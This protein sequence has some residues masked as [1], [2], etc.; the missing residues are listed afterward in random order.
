VNILSLSEIKD[1]TINY[2]LNQ[3]NLIKY[4]KIQILIPKFPRVSLKRNLNNLKSENMMTSII[5]TSVCI[6]YFISYFFF[7]QVGLEFLQ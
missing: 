7:A 1:K 2:L 6:F 4:I 5:S 3:G